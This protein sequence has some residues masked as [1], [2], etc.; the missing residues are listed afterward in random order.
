M[1]KGKVISL[2]ELRKFGSVGNLNEQAKK[3]VAQQKATWNLAAKNYNGAGSV[4]T[5]T[6][7][8]G[9]FSIVAQFNPERI[10]SSAAKTDA[11]SI[12]ERP[13]FLCLKNLPKEQK[14]ILFQEDYVILTN[15]FPIFHAHLTIPS[16]Q[17]KP[18]QIPEYLDDMLKLSRELNDFI[19]FYN[20]PQTGASAP[21]HFHFQAGINGLLPIEKEY[22]E[23]SKNYAEAVLQNSNVK[24]FA[25][26]DYL[27]RFIAIE[28]ANCAAIQHVFN[29][30]YRL[31][32]AENNTEPLLNILCNYKNG[33]WQVIIFPREKQ[34]TSH[35]YKD[36]ENRIVVGPASVELGGM[37]ILPRHEDFN[38]ITQKTIEEIYSEVT[39]SKGVFRQIIQ[40]IKINSTLTLRSK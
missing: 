13:C 27:R 25:V 36:D 2:G 26:S 16:L 20:G 14:G 38:K 5:L 31:L 10:R 9:H 15:P 28:S 37:L 8:F 34:R 6:F 40:Q 22:A 39:I 29:M 7:D 24:V 18:Q 11:K 23:L 3:L 19:V 35:F 30:I 4:Q 33:G 12:A 21:D 1:L 32:P 17:H